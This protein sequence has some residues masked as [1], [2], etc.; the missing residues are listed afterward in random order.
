VD[1]M[2]AR[3]FLLSAAALAAPAAAYATTYMTATQAQAAMFPGQAME[4]A[5][6]TLTDAETAAIRKASGDAP[7]SRELKAWRAADGGWF[8]LD[9]VVGKHEYITYA[10][11]ID[12]AGAV[13]DIEIL[14]YRESYGG[15]VREAPWR[16]QFTGK[17]YGAPL[18]LGGDIRNISGA[19]LSSKHVTDG[20]RRVL[21]AYALVLAPG[22]H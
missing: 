7:L 22:A 5:S 4:L 3:F 9:Q 15:Q 10:V 6:R 12:S 20:V 19:T 18:K 16:A 17:K 11:A 8:I 21:A 13:K 2:S 14:D 1:N